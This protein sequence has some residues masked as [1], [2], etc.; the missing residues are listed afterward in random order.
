MNLRFTLEINVRGD[1]LIQ[2]GTNYTYFDI[3]FIFEIYNPI[4][5]A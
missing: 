5:A 2:I 1:S 3:C 4:W